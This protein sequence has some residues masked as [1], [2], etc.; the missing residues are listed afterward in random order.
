[1]P[2]AAPDFSGGQ[3]QAP[4]R[5]ASRPRRSSR[6]PSS[7]RYADAG[8]VPLT[9]VTRRSPTCRSRL[10]PAPRWVPTKPRQ[11]RGS[12]PCSRGAASARWT[13]SRRS[14]RDDDWVLRTGPTTTGGGTGGGYADVVAPPNL[15]ASTGMGRRDPGGPARPGRHPRD[16]N[17]HRGRPRAPSD[18][19]GEEMELVNPVTAGTELTSRPHSRPSRRSRPVR[20]VCLRHRLNTSPP[21]TARLNARRTVVLRNRAGVLMPTTYK[22]GDLLPACT[23]Q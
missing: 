1:M 19:R 9:H 23:T 22:I 6:A 17:C 8:G 12:G 10:S 13:R 14:L 4:R 15:L 18:G 5:S 21:P 16:G 7:R 20:P 2:T 3:L 11:V